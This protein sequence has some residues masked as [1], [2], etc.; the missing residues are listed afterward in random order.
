[1][2]ITLDYPN[3]YV[4]ILNVFIFI[5]IIEM[6]L[7]SFGETYDFVKKG[8]TL[9]QQQKLLDLRE[10]YQ[11]LQEKNIQLRDLVQ[12]L[13]K[14][15][16]IK[17]SVDYEAPY[18]WFINPDGS[19]DGPF[20]QCCY[21]NTKKLIRLQIIVKGSWHCVVCDNYFKDSSFSPPRQQRYTD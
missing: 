7:P 6:V 16:E 17:D 1:L 8:L 13:E 18:Y 21:D 10:A 9:E 12:S 3:I 15:L 2:K 14:Q 11:S 4:I 20:C 19:K 5:R